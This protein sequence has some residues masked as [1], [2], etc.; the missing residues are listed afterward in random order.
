MRKKDQTMKAKIELIIDYFVYNLL[1][2]EIS[3]KIIHCPLLQPS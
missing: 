3:N 2:P 1:H